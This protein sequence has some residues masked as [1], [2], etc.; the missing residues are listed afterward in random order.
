MNPAS[1]PSNADIQGALRSIE[2]DSAHPTRKPEQQPKPRRLNEHETFK[3][4]WQALDNLI[5]KR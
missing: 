3:R 5:G 4:Y 2:R 1:K